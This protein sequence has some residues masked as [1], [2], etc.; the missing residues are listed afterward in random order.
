MAHLQGTFFSKELSRSTH[1][2]AILC[3]DNGYPTEGNPHFQRPV[4]NVYLLHGYCGNDTDWPDNSPL[5]ELANTYNVNFFTMQ[6]DN[7]FYLNQEASCCKYQN[8]VGKEFIDYTRDTFNLSSRKE[9]TIIGGLS[10]GGFGAI[11]TGLAYPYTF[12]KIIALSSALIINGIKD[13]EPGTGNE[14]ANYAY[15][16][17]VFGD[18]GKLKESNND[19]EY[20][21]DTLLANNTPIPDIFMA[22][23]IEDFLYQANIEFKDYLISK[24]VPVTFW[25]GPG[26]HDF[27]FWREWLVKGLDWAFAD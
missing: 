23:G 3:N 6:G 4:K 20:Q 7:S 17:Q 11:H 15:Y 9:D 10:M 14:V 19:P 22:V 24:N 16:Y 1:F 13:M 12:G 26:V 21:I 27:K 5:N 25:D 2:Q 8:F 18:L